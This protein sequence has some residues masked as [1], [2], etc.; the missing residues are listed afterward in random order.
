MDTLQ[1]ENLLRADCRLSTSFE[2]VFA[3]DQLPSFCE[4][5]CPA[6]LVMNLDP[7][8]RGGSHWVC[9]YVDGKTR[10]GEY[11]DSYG[12]RPPVEDFVKFLDRNCA[13]WTY[14]DR[15]LQSLDTD[16]CGHYCIWF[17]S[18]RARGRSMDEIVAGFSP[19]NT[20]R[21]DAAVRKRVE[22]R[23]GRIADDVIARGGRGG[24]AA[25]VQCC[26]ARVR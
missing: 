20:A 2:G 21:N 16:V 6:A 5:S 18:E 10:C 4:S 17:L 9:I 7:S 14:N 12:M 13:R 1:I 11:F 24:N 23:F 15:E 3:S 25:A 22:T 26:C 8:S 19:S